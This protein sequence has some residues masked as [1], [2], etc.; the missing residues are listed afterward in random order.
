MKTKIDAHRYCISNKI[1]HAYVTSVFH[2]QN[3]VF[4][5]ALCVLCGK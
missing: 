1:N 2:I 4:L 3:F 5:G